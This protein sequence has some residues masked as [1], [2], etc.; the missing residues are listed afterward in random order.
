MSSTRSRRCARF[1]FLRAVR[2]LRSCFTSEPSLVAASRAAASFVRRFSIVSASGFAVG[3]SSGDGR[4]FLAIFLGI[5]ALLTGP[6][7]PAPTR[8]HGRPAPA[9]RRSALDEQALHRPA[10]APALV[11]E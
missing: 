2:Y 4:S 8:G 3:T 1:S 11:P 9:P 5:G 7:R 10:E 6:D